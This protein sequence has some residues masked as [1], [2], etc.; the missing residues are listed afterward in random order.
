MYLLLRCLHRYSDR[1]KGDRLHL[2]EIQKLVEDDASMKDLSQPQHQEFI[3]N[4]KKYRETNKTGVR[5]SNK[6]AALDCRGVVDRVS[7][8]V[9]IYRD[10]LVG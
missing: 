8:E 7:T 6:L 9:C 3:D 10:V 1:E 4:L 2:A 5:A